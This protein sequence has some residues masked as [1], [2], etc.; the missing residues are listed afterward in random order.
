MIT[1][2]LAKLVC[3]FACS[4]VRSFV[5]LFFATMVIVMVFV[6]AT[7]SGFSIINVLYPYVC[8][9][10]ESAL[11]INAKISTIYLRMTWISFIHDV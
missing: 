6:R 1:L 7:P 3:L 10:K 11:S 4:F 9:L 8:Y 2:N 5:C